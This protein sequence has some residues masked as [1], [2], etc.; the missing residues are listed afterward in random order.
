M[1]VTFHWSNEVILI[2]IMWIL[3]VISCLAPLF[4]ISAVPHGLK[5][6]L[7]IIILGSVI[8]AAAYSPL[9]LSIDSD[10]VTLKKLI[11]QIVIPLEEI[12]TVKKINKNA[13]S[14]S[15]R[16][17]GSGGVF[18]YLGRFKNRNLGKYSMYITE[19]KN[20]ILI[21]TENRQYVF[22]CSEPDAFI[23]IYHES[24]E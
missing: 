5:W 6:L 21:K 13:I 19:R 22:N 9:S 20:L 16:T 14:G 7:G 17:F 24:Q 15:I 3:V 10:K 8:F 23:K 1:T 4:F 12:R 11:G 18:G 2:T